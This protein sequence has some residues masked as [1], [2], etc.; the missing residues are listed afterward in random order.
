MQLKISGFLDNKWQQVFVQTLLLNVCLYLF[1]NILN[2]S[3]HKR[4]RGGKKMSLEF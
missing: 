1:L 2:L 4:K 3:S